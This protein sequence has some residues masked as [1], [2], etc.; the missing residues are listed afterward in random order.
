MRLHS[1]LLAGIVLTALV[2]VRV[3]AAPIL[4]TDRAVFEAYVQPDLQ[5]TFDS[6]EIYPFTD[7]CQAAAQCAVIADNILQ[8]WWSDFVAGSDVFHGNLAMYGSTQNFGYADLSLGPFERYRD[9]LYGDRLRCLVIFLSSLGHRRWLSRHQLG[10]RDGPD[11]RFCR[12][13]LSSA[14]HSPPLFLVFG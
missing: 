10:S 7:F 6:V 11:T 1:G 2:P 8:V 13:R 14:L 3:Q 4:F 9:T 12:R 5:V